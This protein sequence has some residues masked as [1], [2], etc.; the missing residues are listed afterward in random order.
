MAINTQT[1][2]D[3][4]ALQY[5]TGVSTTRFTADFIQAVNRTISDFRSRLNITASTISSLSTNIEIDA[6]YEPTFQFGV[7]Y[8][9]LSV[10]GY[11][12]REQGNVFQQYRESMRFARH[13]RTSEDVVVDGSAGL[14]GKFGDL[15]AQ[16]E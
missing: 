14:K 8:Y 13:M 6:K 5:G 15:A 11:N 12:N 9:L 10:G 4:K 3:Q 7:D 2:F 16:T 1:L